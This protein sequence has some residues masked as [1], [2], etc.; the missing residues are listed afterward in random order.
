MFT[1]GVMN[2]FII[3]FTAFH[4]ALSA[5][6]PRRFPLFLLDIIVYR[7]RLLLKCLNY[8]LN[9]FGISREYFDWDR[10]GVLT[11]SRISNCT[12]WISYVWNITY[13]DAQMRRYTRLLSRSHNFWNPCLLVTDEVDVAIFVLRHSV[14]KM[15]DL[16]WKFFFY[17]RGLYGIFTIGRKNWRT[18]HIFITLLFTECGS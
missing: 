4:N 12:V 9:C 6:S 8:Q 5:T 10:V 17:S 15:V 11:F 14:V 13:S 3:N 7:K 2:W 16:R 1:M 18:F